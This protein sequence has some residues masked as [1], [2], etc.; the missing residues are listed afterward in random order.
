M[1]GQGANRP[2]FALPLREG[3]SPNGSIARESARARSSG[4]S[5]HFPDAP[6]NSPSRTDPSP[7]RTSET[8]GQ[9]DIRRRPLGFEQSVT[10][11]PTPPVRLL[12]ETDSADTVP[13]NHPLPQLSFRGCPILALRSTQDYSAPCFFLRGREFLA[14]LTLY[15]VVDLEVLNRLDIP[16]TPTAQFWSASIRNGEFLLIGL[17]HGR[18]FSRYPVQ[19][20]RLRTPGGRL[21]ADR[22]CLQS[23]PRLTR[24]ALCRSLLFE[25]DIEIGSLFVV[26]LFTSPD[27]DFAYNFLGDGR[28]QSSPFSRTLTSDVIHRP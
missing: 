1:T 4:G 23:V 20:G 11:S 9:S 18:R 27:V 19:Y 14:L 17:F 16:D 25:V 28:T 3:A 22:P 15:D 21:F 6:R 13:G 8:S 26:F 10:E 12:A 5:I 24:E 7:K 2:E